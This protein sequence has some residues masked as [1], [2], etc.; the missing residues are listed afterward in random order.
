MSNTDPHKPGGLNAPESKSS[1][2]GT[3]RNSK[4]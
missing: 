2:C 1:T 4:V 3:H